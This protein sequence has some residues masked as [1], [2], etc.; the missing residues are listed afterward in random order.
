M[1]VGRVGWSVGVLGAE[2]SGVECVDVWVSG[3]EWGVCYL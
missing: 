1:Y 3:V 2:W